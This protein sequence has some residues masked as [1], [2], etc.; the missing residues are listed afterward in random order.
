MADD[1]LDT[2]WVGLPSLEVDAGP[3]TTCHGLTLMPEVA[4]ALNS[5]GAQ[6]G[7][8]SGGIDASMETVE[9]DKY[10]SG[11]QID[12]GSEHADTLQKREIENKEL[13]ELFVKLNI[14]ENTGSEF[15]TSSFDFKV[16]NDGDTLL[17]T[18]IVINR[19]IDEIRSLLFRYMNV[20]S[21]TCFMQL[22]NYQNRFRFQTPLHLAALLNRPDVVDMLVDLGA[23]TNFR[24]S[25]MR[26]PLH[27]ACACMDSNLLEAFFKPALKIPPGS[28]D[29]QNDEGLTCLH[30]T[31]AYSN[32]ATAAILL[33]HGADI[34]ARDGH[35][36]RTALHFAAETGNVGFVRFLMTYLPGSECRGLLNPNVR[37]LDGLTALELAYVRGWAEVVQLLE[38]VSE[39]VR[40]KEEVMNY[41]D[42]EKEDNL[43]HA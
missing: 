7:R 27:I 1:K 24:D 2:T 13:E 34:N 29:L 11:G 30:V 42:N 19:C 8:A 18:A 38:P 31:V 20:L 14:N 36:G 6:K 21:Y 33:Q 12:E 39:P 22:I 37:T 10:N 16:D 3:P 35:S 28:L 23:Q 17:H 25:N 5:N 9:H 26:T 41:S 40:L 4:P 15:L 32:E 43:C